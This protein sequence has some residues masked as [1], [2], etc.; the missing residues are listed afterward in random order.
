MTNKE[1]VDIL[2]NAAWLGTD[3]DR[4]QIEKAVEMAINALT[5]QEQLANNSPKVDS[6]NGELINNK[7]TEKRT[8]THACDCIE[9]QAAID[10]IDKIFPADP[11]RNDYTQGITCGAALAKEYIKQ[12][13]S[14]QPQRTGRWIFDNNDYLTKC[15]ECGCHP[16]FGVIPTAKEATKKLPHCPMCLVKME[17]NNE[18]R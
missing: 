9:R 12:L 4:E 17:E 3:A 10:A 13:A 2:R 18:D 15:S 5:A 16:W 1:A 11:M 8:E 14:A 7:R 6:E